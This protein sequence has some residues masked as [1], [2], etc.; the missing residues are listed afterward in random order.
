MV[1]I[2]VENHHIQYTCNDTVNGIIHNTYLV[3]KKKI[4]IKMKKLE[5]NKVN[6]YNP[7]IIQKQL[8]E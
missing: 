2:R 5:I 6:N 8:S 3:L 7:Y 1:F 4:K